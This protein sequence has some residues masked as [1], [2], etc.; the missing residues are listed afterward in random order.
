MVVR[1]L[2]RVVVRRLAAGL[3]AAPV[4]PAEPR[5]A[6]PE[7]RLLDAGDFLARVVDDRFAVPAGLRFVVARL[8][9][10]DRV[11]PVEALAEEAR[12]GASSSPAQLP[13]ITR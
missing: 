10:V 7:V 8:R 4:A 3:R 5:L 9:P 11:P 12:A 6:A 13:D 1:G 2:D